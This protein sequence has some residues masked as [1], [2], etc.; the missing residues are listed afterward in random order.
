MTTPVVIPITRQASPVAVV[1][2][3][4]VVVAGGTQEPVVIQPAPPQGPQG[5]AGTQVVA[6]PYDQWPPANPLPEVL[7]LRIAP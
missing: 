5:E 1:R 4:V 6:V 7:Y 3:S 2:P